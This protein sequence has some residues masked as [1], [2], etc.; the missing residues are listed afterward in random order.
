MYCDLNTA[1]V[2][3][4]FFT[5]QL[6]QY[7]SVILLFALFGDE[8]EVFLPKYY[9]TTILHA[10]YFRRVVMWPEYC[11]CGVPSVYYQ[12]IPISSFL[13]FLFAPFSEEPEVF[14]KYILNTLKQQYFM[15]TSGG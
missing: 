15:L 14:L 1:S 12:P 4:L 7:L 10:A 13:Y 9:Q 11:H 6:Y 3:F 5:T 2:V 8:P